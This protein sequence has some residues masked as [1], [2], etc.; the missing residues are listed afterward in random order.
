MSEQVYD[1]YSEL[2]CMLCLVMLIQTFLDKSEFHFCTFVLLY[3]NIDQKLVNSLHGLLNC[4]TGGLECR[5]IS[6][7]YRT[8]VHC[9]QM[10]HLFC[11]A[12]VHVINSVVSG[13]YSYTK[14]YFAY[15]ISLKGLFMDKNMEVFTRSLYNITSSLFYIV[16]GL[17]IVAQSLSLVW[18]IPGLCIVAKSLS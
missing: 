9:I 16:P 18:R 4:E 6:T 2:H 8:R 3:T 15:S 12:L 10:Q 1:T 5:V 11:N 14:H 13:Q 7:E 17:C